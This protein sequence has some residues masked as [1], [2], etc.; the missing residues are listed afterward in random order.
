[1]EKWITSFDG[2]PI[3]YDI[4]KGKKS[5]ACL[6]FVHGIGGDLAAWNRERHYFHKKGFSTLALDLRGH[7][8]SGRPHLSSD[9][10]LTYFAKDLY[11]II[12]HEKIKKFIL[13][14]HCFGGII[15]TMFHKLHPRLAKAYILID[16]TFKAPE[17]LRTLFSNYS[18]VRHFLNLLLKNKHLGRRKESPVDYG[19]F[20]GTGDYDLKR[21]YSDITHT[22]F[23][24]WILTFQNLAHF[25]G[26]RILKSIT[27][28]VLIVEGEKDSIFNVLKAQ[29]IHD[30]VK[31]S[32]LRIIPNENHIIVLNNPD[33][34]V[35]EISSF[36]QSIGI[37]E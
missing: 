1:M 16:T 27:Q 28:P 13:I 5:D 2:T 17:P 37:E 14:G 33:V 12:R 19:K 8:K 11:M 31:G 23:K 21:I 34:L 7:G 4:E 15:T 18:L 32:T 3:H 25:N 35:K 29:K 10:G 36:L 24:S 6:I 30:L 22:S 9:Y 20:V 26:I